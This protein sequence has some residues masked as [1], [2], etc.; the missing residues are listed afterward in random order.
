MYMTAHRSK[1]S[2][3][4]LRRRRL[5]LRLSLDEVALRTGIDRSKLSRAE[6]KYAHLTVEE[7]KRVQRVLG[8]NPTPTK[9]S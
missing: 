4:P 2:I 5:R 9:R 3:S 8:M 6:R 1:T 7:M